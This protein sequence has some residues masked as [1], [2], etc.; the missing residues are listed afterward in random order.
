MKLHRIVPLAVV[1]VMI[2]VLLVLAVIS[3][4]PPCG[5]V[6]VTRVVISPPVGLSSPVLDEPGVVTLMPVVTSAGSTSGLS[7]AGQAVKLAQTTTNNVPRLQ[8]I[9]IKNTPG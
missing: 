2:A 7:S 5:P 9:I 6:V 3:P 4:V 8:I 1:G